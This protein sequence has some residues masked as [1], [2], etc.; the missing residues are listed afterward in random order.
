MI[1]NSY[2]KMII[3]KIIRL[4]TEFRL[5]IFEKEKKMLLVTHLVK[6]QKKHEQD[7]TFLLD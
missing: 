2:L 5:L 3:K 6:E 1:N 4:T 7:P